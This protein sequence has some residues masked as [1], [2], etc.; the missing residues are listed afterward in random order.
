MHFLPA[1]L[2]AAG[3]PVATTN[4]CFFNPAIPTRQQAL[5]ED[6]AVYPDACPG[7]SLG[8]QRVCR[9]ML[10]YAS[11]YFGGNRILKDECVLVFL[12]DY[13]ADI[14]AHC[15]HPVTEED[16]VT[17]PTMDAT[18]CFPEPKTVENIV[19]IGKG[20]ANKMPPI[21]GPYTLIPKN[22]PKDPN[23]TSNVQAH[24]RTLAL[25]RQARNFYT[26]DKNTLMSDEAALCGCNVFILNDAGVFEEQP[27]ALERAQTQ[28][29]IPERAVAIAKKFADRVHKFFGETGIQINAA[30]APAVA[31]QQAAPASKQ[32]IKVGVFTMD[33]ANS[34]CARLRLLDALNYLQARGDVE[35]LPLCEVGNGRVTLLKENIKQA[36]I[37]VVQRGM[38]V[39]LPYHALRAGIKDPAVKIIFELDDALTQLPDENPHAGYYRAMQPQLEAYLRNADL[40]TVSTPKL[41]EI[42]SSYNDRIE[43]VANS[44][45][46][47]VWLPVPEKTRTNNKV[48]I[49]FSGTLTHQ[50]DLA[51]IEKAI[52]QIIGEF[53]A[54]VEFLFWGNLPASLKH[55]PQVKSAAQ[56]TQDYS[57]Y[58][59]YL[60]TMTVDFAL[61]PLAVT[62]FN[63][64]KSNVK[65]LEYSACKIP[66]IFTDISA[67]NQTVEHGKTGWLVPNTVEAWHSAMKRLIEDKTLRQGLG[68]NAH[69]AVV[70]RHSLAANADRWLDA[71]QT[72]LTAPRKTPIP[73]KPEASIIIP[74]F[75]NLNLTR[76]CLAALKANTPA[77][78]YE[79]IIVD[80][81]S[82]DGTREFLKSDEQAGRVR[83]IQNRENLGFARAC[84]QGSQIAKADLLLFLNNDTKV[85]SGWLEALTGAMRR[86][87]AGIAGA[88]L[89]YADGTIQHAGIGFIGDLPD[90]PNRHAATDAPEVNKFRELDMVTGACLMIRRDLFQQLA[91]FDESYRNGVEDIDLCLRARA[92]GWKV[93]YEPKAVVFHLE[94]QSVGRFN[95]VAQNLRI[96]FDRWGKMFDSQKNFVLSKPARIISS[97]ASLLLVKEKSAPSKPVTVAW[98]GTYLDY[99]SLSHVNRQFARYLSSETGV[100]LSLVST[101]EMAGS[102]TAPEL[103][104]LGRK[105]KTAPPAGVQVTVRHQWPPNWSRPAQ[106]SLVVIQPWEFG[107]L[108]VDWVK[109]AENVDEFWLPSNYVRQVYIESGVPAEK[110]VVVPNGIDP[111]VYRE[112]VE[113][114]ELTTKKKFRFLFVGGT[115]H[116]K[117]PDVLLNAYVNNFTAADDVCLVIKDFGGKTFY[118]GQTIEKQIKA[119]QARPNA[120]EILYLTDEMPAAA[121]PLLYAACHCLV[122]PYRG[123]GFGLPVLEAMA[124]GLPV[125]VTAGGSTD[126]FADEEHAYR[127]DAQRKGIG[128]EISGLKLAHEGWLLEPDLSALGA[129]MKRVVANPEEAK[130]TG[131]AASEYVRREWTWQRA[132]QIAWARLQELTLRKS[133]NV[134]ANTPVRKVV[135]LTLPDTARIGHLGEAQELFRRRNLKDAIDSVN[136]AI[137]ARPFHPEGYV[138]LG[139]LARSFGDITSARRCAEHA[140]KLTP[141]WKPAEQ[142]LKALPKKSP[143]PASIKLPKALTE[144]AAAKPGLSV[145]LIV[146]NEEEFIAQCLQSVRDIAAQIIVVDT[147]STDRTI[148]IAKEF[149]A[150]IYSFPWNDDFAA[151]RNE[152]LKHARGEWVL[153]IDADEELYPEH[154]QTIFEEMQSPLVLGYRV[155]IFNKGA[156]KEGCGY[157]PRL[158]RN[159]PAVFF[160]GRIHEEIFSSLE[161]HADKWGM[162]SALARTAL[163][164]HGYKPEVVASRSKI[165]RNLRLLKRA[166]EELP[167]EPN[168]VMNL[169]L[170]LIRS[171]EFEEGLQKYRDAVHL[172]SLLPPGKATPEFCESLLTQLTTNLLGAARYNEI[173]ELWQQPFPRSRMMSASQHFMLG[174]AQMELKQPAAAAEQMRQCLTKRA[175]PALSPINKH[176][177]TATPRHCLAVSLAALGLESESGKAFEEALRED[178]KARSVRIDYARFQAQY[179]RPIES[180]KLLHQVVSENGQDLEAWKLGGQIALAKAEFL[181]FAFNWTTEAIKNFP[182]DAV[183]MQQRA[184]A[185]M[186]NQHIEAALPLWT[187]AHSPDSSRHLAALTI[188]EVLADATERN[189]SPA[190]ERGVSQEFLRWYRYLIALKASAAVSQINAKMDQFQLVLPTAASVLNKAMKNADAAMAV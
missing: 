118:A 38:P 57:I 27:K 92:A 41:K 36:Q 144:T 12:K 106:G 82:T 2:N 98:E 165:E 14:Q 163:L 66:A 146:K 104:E 172:T 177:L 6:I 129:A 30:P 68:E 166:V 136:A 137:E 63:E 125:I 19:Y 90:H 149:N 113:P 173:V 78:H 130:H 164:H 46:T 58:A 88:K 126:D 139:E 25:L 70:E 34:A 32:K 16:I 65:W 186:L 55:L 151:A 1:L 145:C 162:Q 127:I 178:P 85:T 142:L 3:V 21:P 114:L 33:E 18:W 43:V 105:L 56:F 51:L 53:G 179:G 110:I 101:R 108:P 182:E 83:V 89:L 184:E 158:F 155:A 76:D 10:Y 176:I 13:L 31:K 17:F 150:E 39:C 175:L 79:I 28:V 26:L 180:L 100:D 120:P 123:E 22:P 156:E 134:P 140:V 59:R 161:A 49:L 143:K 133:S 37:I 50:G 187:R 87:Q 45:D 121:M 24:N 102:N 96:F 189:F 103:Q 4:P 153:S 7:N 86:T 138:L 74:V 154:K 107:S 148:E 95:H 9:Y 60:K 160:V 181:D 188:C 111:E 171:G 29:M 84:N 62:P 119:L 23:Y 135:A 52:E 124:C 69:Q 141:H 48:S 67:Y 80:N 77:G 152:A 64:A 75:N 170:E 132:A 73:E 109:A 159:A 112:G 99:G 190:Q 168:F 42:Y 117:G 128:S 185:L 93:V 116:R 47:S 40:V 157:V 8:A 35:Y 131:H 54:R 81:A 97:Q 61:V 169:G 122:H 94:G 183:V 174:L 5:P 147:G 15:D 44:V 20:G 11:A 167:G 72:T 115:I 91:G 71:Y